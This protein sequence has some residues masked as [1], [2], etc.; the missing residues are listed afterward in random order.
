MH[1]Y[2][3]TDQSRTKIYF[4]IAA[5]ALFVCPWINGIISFFGLAGCVAG[6]SVFGGLFFLIDR[7]AWS[8]KW[9]APAF[10]TPNLTGTYEVTGHTSGADGE[11]RDWTGR[12]TIVQRW[13]SMTVS[14][15]TPDSGSSSSLSA[16][17]IYP[18]RGVRLVYGFSNQ[19]DH[20][21]NQLNDHVGMCSVLFDETLSNATANY[22]TG[23]GRATTG[24]MTWTRF[25]EE[26]N[27]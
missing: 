22:F 27:E 26:T 10:G 4:V 2:N 5:I 15:V 19:R 13:S 12:V 3:I 23:H 17:E 24:S 16:I 25:T 20:Q 9:L 8:Q 11:A 7:W 21:R 18:G 1:P 14:M 6:V